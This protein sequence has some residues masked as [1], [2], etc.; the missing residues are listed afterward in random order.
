MK[1]KKHGLARALVAMAFLGASAA[2]VAATLKGPFVIADSRAGKEGRLYATEKPYG[3]FPAAVHLVPHPAS[4]DPDDRF[5]WDDLEEVL[6]L[7]DLSTVIIPGVG[8]TGN[9][10]APSGHCLTTL[11]QHPFPAVENTAWYSCDHPDGFKQWTHEEGGRLS[12]VIKGAKGYLGYV[13]G[14]GLFP[15]P[16]FVRELAPGDAKFS[17]ITELFRPLD[18]R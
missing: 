1:M 17:L 6:A 9:I 2:T 18:G 15:G 12:Q 7:R 5:V 4:A 14:A 10:T 16:Q 11:L 8:E 13:N 3:P